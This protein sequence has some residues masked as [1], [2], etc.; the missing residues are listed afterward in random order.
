MPKDRFVAID[1]GAESGRA[2]LASLENDRLSLEE[3]HRFSTPVGRMNGSLYWNLLGIWE[4]V[5]AGLRRCAVEGGQ[6]RQI[7]SIGVDAWGVDFGLIA[8]SGEILGDPVHY[9]DRRTD[10]V[11]E[12][13]FQRVSKQRIFDIT[14]VQFMPINTLYQL[15]AMQQSKSSL[16]AAAETLLFIP[17]LFNYLLT[18]KKQSEYSIATTSQM[19][20]P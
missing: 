14:G 19:F 17:D 8:P 6:K 18:G 15:V 13:V 10:G 9:R 20:N 12:K 4:E 16:L 1:I 11:M 5:K 3:R 2:V 7:D